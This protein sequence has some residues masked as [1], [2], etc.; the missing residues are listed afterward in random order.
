MDLYLESVVPTGISAREKNSYTL[1]KAALD[2]W[3][4]ILNADPDSKEGLY[5]RLAFGTVH[6]T[7]IL[8]SPSP[9]CS[10]G[11]DEGFDLFLFLPK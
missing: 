10:N 11:P 1:P 9:G 7:L 8:R 4:K 3:K 5:L 6:Q 2:I